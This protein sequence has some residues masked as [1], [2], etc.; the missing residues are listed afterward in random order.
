[1]ATGP[2]LAPPFQIGLSVPLIY[3]NGFNAV[4]TNSEISAFLL[5]DNQP[6]IKV[7]MPLHVAKTLALVLNDLIGKYEQATSTKVP[8]IEE[9]GQLLSKLK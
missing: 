5:H 6:S 2:H 9:L 3:F 4:L 8:T 7:A 1:M